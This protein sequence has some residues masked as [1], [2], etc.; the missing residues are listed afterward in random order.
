VESRRGIVA[1]PAVGLLALTARSLIACRNDLAK[2]RETG[3]MHAQTAVIKQPGLFNIHTSYY[4]SPAP[5][6]HIILV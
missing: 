4:A 6:R 5:R 1:F 2:R 3:N